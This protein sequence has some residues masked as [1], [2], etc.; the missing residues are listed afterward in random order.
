MERGGSR[1]GK[2]LHDRKQHDAIEA[3]YNAFRWGLAIRGRV[4]NAPFFGRA[5]RSK[6]GIFR[7]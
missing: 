4:A 7:S 6:N 2:D 3:N 5:I 1:R